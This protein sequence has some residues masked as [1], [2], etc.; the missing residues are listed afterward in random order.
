M[1]DRLERKG[2][3]NDTNNNKNNDDDSNSKNTVPFMLWHTQNFKCCMIYSKR[4][5]EREKM[6]KRCENVGT[7]FMDTS[8][9]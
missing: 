3:E 9:T 5:N 6:K 7:F 8:N 4:K 2:S 1:W